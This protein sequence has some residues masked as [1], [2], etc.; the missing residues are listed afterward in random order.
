MK[1]RKTL[2]IRL[3][4][5]I[6]LIVIA[7]VL[8]IVLA[9]EMP[10]IRTL[11]FEAGAYDVP[12]PAGLGAFTSKK[13]APDH[14]DLYVSPDGSD[15]ADGSRANPLATIERARE[16][17]RDM[18]KSGRDGITVELLPG[19]YRIRPLTFGREDGGTTDCPV[20]YRASG[21]GEV[22]LNGGMTLKKTDF[23]PLPQAA[24]DR[25]GDDAKQHVLTVDLTKL[26]LTADDWGKLYPVGKYSTA[27]KYDGDTTGPVPCALYCDGVRM[28][29]AR[30]PNEGF[31]KVESVVREGESRENSTSNH[32]VWPGWETVRNPQTTIFRADADTARRIAGYATTDGVWLWTAL[33][34]DWADATTPLKSFDPDE[35][36]I[37][38]AYVSMFGAVPGATYY[39]FNALEELDSPGEW[40][41]DREKGL[42]Y[43]WPVGTFDDNTV[44][45]LSLGGEDLIRVED[46]SHLRFD[47]LTVK[48]SRGGGFAIRGDDNVLSNCHVTEVSG[49][50]AAIDGYRNTVSACEFIHIGGAAVTVTGGDRQT[51][52]PGENRVDNCLIRDYS[53]VSVTAG[54]GVELR[55]VGNACSHNEICFAPQQA[56]LYG[57][58]DMLIEY[59]DIHDV[60]LLSDDCGAIY[61]GRRWDECGSVIRYN[62]LY[63]LGDGDHAPNAIYWDDAQAGQ[64]AYGNLILNCRQNGLLIGGGRDH[65]VTGNVFVNC[66]TPICCDERAREGAMD[67]DSWF[68]H[69]MEG[70]DMQ[71]HL[72]ES[73]WQSPVW[74]AKYPYMAEWSLDYGDPENA[75][76]VPNPA[77]SRVTG[78][79]IVQHNGSLGSVAE[80]AARF[81]DFT[82]NAVFALGDLR[83]LFA[84]PARGE[85]G[86]KADAPVFAELPA[87]EAL[88][89]ERIGRY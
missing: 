33:A 69:S 80:S 4:A 74:Q 83:A 36:T 27:D 75:R 28:T 15:D 55:G 59:N 34:Y 87:F 8:C 54:A 77:G 76:F 63:A 3:F 49:V 21:D 85:Y 9:C 7:A 1:R 12:A 22:I 60:A 46:A 58:N 53:E 6:A 73:P 68:K 64:T 25:L 40:Y 42:L 45:T 5:V 44:L 65:V 66:K 52:T 84:D 88:P 32:S 50:G 57:G 61:C 16:L 51:L 72:L 17:V 47:G 35:R 79:L 43:F 29:T 11:R 24:A 39:I 81:S 20:T 67:P 19:E 18:D 71:T 86:L 62:A 2:N 14:A 89:L 38:P 56:V 23:G 48:G 70:A 31:L 41:L 13:A 37:E 10:G 26:G 82:G 78:N 30:Y